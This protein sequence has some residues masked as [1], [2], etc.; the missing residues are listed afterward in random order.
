[1][2]INIVSETKVTHH[3]ELLSESVQIPGLQHSDLSKFL[4]QM[5]PINKFRR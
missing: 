4:E 5:T 3:L 1:M 2:I